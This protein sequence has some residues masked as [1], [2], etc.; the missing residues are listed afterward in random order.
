MLNGLLS[1]HDLEQG[2]GSE[3]GV[4]RTEE[5]A[6]ALLQTKTRHVHVM[7]GEVSQ[8]QL[9]EGEGN[10]GTWEGSCGKRGVIF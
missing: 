10:V 6:A 3:V 4:W 7:V 9:H 2:L 8:Q 5:E 1:H